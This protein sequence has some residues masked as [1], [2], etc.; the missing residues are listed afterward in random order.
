MEKLTCPLDGAEFAIWHWAYKGNDPHPPVLYWSHATG[1]HGPTYEPLLA[2][3]ATRFHVYAGDARGHGASQP[4][5]LP[6]RLGDWYGHRDDLI[7]II[8]FIHK[9]H[10]KTRLIL[11]G[12]S[13]GATTS[14]LA[15]K[16]MENKPAALILVE[17][18]VMDWFMRYRDLFGRYV[19]R[20]SRTQMMA[21]RAMRR[22]AE[23]PNIDTMRNAYMGRD[24]FASWQTAFL[25][26]YLA[27][28]TYPTNDGSVRL[29]CAP[30]WEAAHYRPQKH[31]LMQAIRDIK[32]PFAL[33]TS[34][35]GS[36]CR[37]QEDFARLKCDSIIIK[38]QATTHHLPMEN[39]SLVRAAIYALLAFI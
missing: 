1:F 6:A 12:H 28:G 30:E 37:V 33:L 34:G 8:R 9:R 4:S 10:S 14:L 18:V 19:L 39:P 36:T 27:H 5:A 35:I 16:V 31:D 32:T 7:E 20:S 13:L 23:W 29:A 17:P 2:P 21:G 25:D 15:S 38:A 26:A 11:G 24:I 3:L 22:R